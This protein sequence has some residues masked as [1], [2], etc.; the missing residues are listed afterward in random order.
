MYHFYLSFNRFISSVLSTGSSPSD[1][2]YT[3]DSP[4][5]ARVSESS[6]PK[7]KK[8]GIVWQELTPPVDTEKE[9]DVSIQAHTTV[10]Q[11]ISIVKK[12]FVLT[13]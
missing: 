6:K 9:D 3:A 13:N 5:S 11:K 7:S 12:I 2:N 10:I 1:I 4:P 8:K